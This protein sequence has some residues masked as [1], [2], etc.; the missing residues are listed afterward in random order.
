MAY[1]NSD[2]TIVIAVLLWSMQTYTFGAET[3]L[4]AGVMSDFVFLSATIVQGLTLTFIGSTALRKGPWRYCQ[5]FHSA[6]TLK[7]WNSAWWQSCESRPCLLSSCYRSLNSNSYGHHMAC[8][9]FGMSHHLTAYDYTGSLWTRLEHKLVDGNRVCPGIHMVRV[10]LATR[11]AVDTWTR[12][13][14]IK[15]RVFERHDVSA[16]LCISLESCRKH[17]SSSTANDVFESLFKRTAN[18]KFRKHRL[19]ENNQTDSEN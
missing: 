10:K 15:K 13:K 3:C 9:L 19:T 14:S 12:V 4:G 7:C 6:L 11:S 17:V 16:W 2:Y 5:D 1:K 8:A 18:T